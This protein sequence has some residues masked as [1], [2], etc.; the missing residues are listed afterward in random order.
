MSITAKEVNEL[1]QLTGSGM[2][3]CKKALVEA[4]GDIQA[5]IDYLRKK[6]AKVA[7]LRAGRE[8]N[9][10]AVIALTSADGK[11][12][13]IV[14]ITCETDFVAKNEA[15]VAFTR[16]IAEHALVNK[17]DSSE[18]LLESTLEGSTVHE[19]I[20]GKV[21]S[22]GEMITLGTYARMT[23]EDIVAYIHG[24]NRMGVLVALN[25]TKS[26]KIDA[27]GKDVAMQI[28]AMNPVAIDENS[29]SPEVVERE[30]AIIVEQMKLDPKMVGK[31]DEMIGKIADGK[32]SA[33]FKENT[34]LNQ[35]FVKDTS[36][37]VA[38]V[39]KETSADLTVTQFRRVTLGSN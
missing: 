38:Q 12:G 3:D 2:M 19:M 34:L 36:K 21:S 35:A 8:S 39:L 10:G 28:A 18:A 29:V 14:R 22:I 5:A 24:N 33:F 23:G 27:I 20:L 13:V 15:F 11:E 17:F 32:M 7:E 26:E 37:S 1:R 25:Q 16:S 30:K 6:G 31:P 9:E 4:N